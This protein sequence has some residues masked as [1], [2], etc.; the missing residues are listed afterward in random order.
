V[1]ILAGFAASGFAALGY[2]VV[3]TR[4]LA[5]VLRITTT[6]SLSTML[7]VFLAGLAAGGAAGARWADRVRRLPLA[8]AGVEIALGL[9]GLASIVAFGSLPRLVEWIGPVYSFQGHIGRLLV[10]GAFV[11]LVPVFLMGA[12]FPIAAR[13]L[14][15]SF[16]DL[17]SR[18][19]TAYA[20][21]TAGAVVGAVATGFLL[22]PLLGSLRSLEL[23]ATTN[24]AV[25]V[26]VL[27]VASGV[28]PLT[29]VAVGGAAALALVAGVAL[30]PAETLVDLHARGGGRLLHHE[31]G[32]SGTVTV[33]ELPNGH[34]LLRV[35]G[36]GEVP[37]DRGSIQTFRL[38]GSLPMVLHEAPEDVLVIAYGGGITL[39]TVASFGPR[40]VECV[41][42][43]PGVVDASRHFAEHNARIHER[44][45]EAGVRMVFDDGRN[46]VRRTD[47]RYDVIV[48]DSTH[49][50][51]ADSWVL[52]TVDFYELCRDRLRPGGMMAQWLPLHGLSPEQ[53]RTIVRTFAAAFPHATL[54]LTTD[55]SVMLGSVEPVEVDMARLAERLGRPGVR[56]F[57]EPVDLADPIS[58]ASTL[59]LDGRALAAFV[60]QGPINTDDLP[61]VNFADRTRSD[62]REGLPVLAGLVPYLS[63][64][65]PG[66]IAPSSLVEHAGLA[67]R[68]AAR[69]AMLGGVV[70]LRVGERSLASAE[71][72]RAQAIDAGEP[73]SARVLEDVTLASMP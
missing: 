70:A 21:N 47:R 33:V 48:S 66:A 29:R 46:H 60:G 53:Y 26:A 50:S 49:P 57:L 35:N 10:A 72:R 34:R 51:T 64:R 71:L 6:Q 5:T 67:R 43:V 19:G 32:S 73:E 41:E 54:W 69:R 63:E 14:A 45:D 25:G 15:S 18:V 65:P 31:E 24:V 40:S 17:G 61:H 12:L 44:L 36:A 42:V 8:F 30:V 9:A 28:R 38:L 1:A 59:A 23:L 22:L 68:C 56:P 55:Y 52:Y 39:G 37:T 3:W 7:I 62:T 27:A 11:M 13:A 58:F 4:L 20:A 16:S 2:E